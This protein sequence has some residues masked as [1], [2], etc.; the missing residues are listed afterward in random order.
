MKMICEICKRDVPDNYIEKHHL[1]PKS[2]KHKSPKNDKPTMNVCVNCGDQIHI[3]FTNKELSSKFNT[4]DA[5]L[6]SDKIQRW[7][8]WIHNKKI[9]SVPRQLKKR[10]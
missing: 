8:D 1:V 5:L 2:R 10:R 9:L 6:A 3:L 7:I 4:I